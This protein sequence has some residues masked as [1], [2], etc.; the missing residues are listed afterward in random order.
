MLFKWRR[1]YRQGLL[2]HGS[3]SMVPVTV[4]EPAIASPC[5]SDATGLIE[6]RIRDAVVRV[7]GAIEDRALASVIRALRA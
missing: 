5:V 4:T 6:I 1:E 3:A 7:K 2:G